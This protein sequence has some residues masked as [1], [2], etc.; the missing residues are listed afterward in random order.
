LK[1]A[2]E[3]YLYKKQVYEYT[4]SQGAPYNDVMKAFNEYQAAKQRY[5]ALQRAASAR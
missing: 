3:V 4:V 2:Y 1:A 5:A